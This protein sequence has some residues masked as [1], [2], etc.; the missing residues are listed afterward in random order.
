M[1]PGSR[2]VLSMSQH[3]IL[4]KTCKKFGPTEIA[5]L[6]SCL[7]KSSQHFIPSAIGRDRGRTEE[8]VMVMDNQVIYCQ[9]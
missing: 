6:D 4:P 9:S 7:T 5:I 3:M 2:A 1:L 8:A